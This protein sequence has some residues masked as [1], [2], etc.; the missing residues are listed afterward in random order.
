MSWLNRLSRS[1][2][3]F[4]I[5]LPRHNSKLPLLPHATH[6]Q[7]SE[8]NRQLACMACIQM[9]TVPVAIKASARRATS[10]LR[11][12]GVGPASRERMQLDA[13]RSFD[14]MLKFDA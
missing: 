5:A 4:S 1:R 8:L 3:V 9:G 13:L 11:H 2:R 7:V 14:R 12:F 10:K 6:L